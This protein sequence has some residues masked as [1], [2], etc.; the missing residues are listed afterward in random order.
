MFHVFHF[1]YIEIGVVDLDL[2]VKLKYR[3]FAY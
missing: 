3:C 1:V 2:D